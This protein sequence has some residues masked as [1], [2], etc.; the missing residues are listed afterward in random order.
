MNENMEL[1]ESYTYQKETNSYIQNQAKKNPYCMQINEISKNGEQI[2]V[3]YE[4]AFMTPEQLTE[5]MIGKDIP[6]E[7]KKVKA[8]IMNNT[9]YQYAKYFV[10]KI[11][12]I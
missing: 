5:Y 7:T 11:E 6:L 8:S 12:N 1:G 2:E 9:D 10:S 3:T 4:L